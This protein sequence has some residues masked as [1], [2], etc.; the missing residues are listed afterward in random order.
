M[1]DAIE[2]S[3]YTKKEDIY[4][5]VMYPAVMVGPVQKLLITQVLE[6]KT[7]ARII[8]PFHGSGTALYE[9]FEINHT[10]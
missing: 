4:G 10:S 6:N 7:E 2:F 8:D 5:T 3:K 9:A 1:L